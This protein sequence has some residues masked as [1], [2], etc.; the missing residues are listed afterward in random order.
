[1][2]HVYAVRDAPTLDAARAAAD[3]F[4]RP[5]ANEYPSAVACSQDDLG[6]LLGL[7]RVPV[8]H[9]VALR[10]TNLAER[11]FEEG[12]RRAKVVPRLRSE[13]AAIKLVFATMMRSAGRWSRLP[14]N[15]LE[16]RQLAL[17]E[18]AS[19]LTPHLPATTKGTKAGNHKGQQHD[20]GHLRLQ[21]A[22]D[23][24]HA[25]WAHLG[26][27]RHE[28]LAAAQPAEPTRS[29]NH[30]PPSRPGRHGRSLARAPCRAPLSGRRWR[31][32]RRCRAATARPGLP[33]RNLGTAQEAVQRAE[34]EGALPGSRRAFYFRSRLSPPSRRTRAPA[35]FDR[36]G[37]TPARH[38]ASRAFALPARTRPSRTSKTPSSTLHVVGS[39][40]T[41]PKSPGSS[42]P[43]RQP[44]IDVALSAMAT[45]RSVSTCPGK[46][47]EAPE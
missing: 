33:G 16:R 47:E 34:V 35:P 20:T 18:Q 22:P 26:G 30:R 23:L 9:R 41:C 42:R 6:A 29:T 39:E 21:D 5:C 12:R 17:A 45:A 40:A 32:S 36:S 27:S 25:R 14:V 28:D 7:H 15:E 37:T 8:R 4:T 44:E 1:M 2:A 43:L 38:A 31:W 24:T 13:R 19:A 46:S 10:T 3:R 11:S